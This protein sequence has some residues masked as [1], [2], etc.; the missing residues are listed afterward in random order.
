MGF[1]MPTS[2]DALSKFMTM[3]TPTVRFQLSIRAT[4]FSFDLVIRRLNL[5]D[6]PEV[7]SSV[8]FCSVL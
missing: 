2:S 6:M 3:L 1:F 8:M 7:P 5:W 4:R